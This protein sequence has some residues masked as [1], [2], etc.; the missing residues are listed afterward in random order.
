MNIL[1]NTVLCR[2]LKS[3]ENKITDLITVT[4]SLFK[5]LK[6]LSAE[7]KLL[8]KRIFTKWEA[9]ANQIHARF[10]FENCSSSRNNVTRHVYGN[11]Q[12]IILNKEGTLLSGYGTVSFPPPPTDSDCMKSVKLELCLFLGAFVK[13]RKANISFVMSV[14]LSRLPLDGFS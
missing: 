13:L 5:S 2:R 6:I 1:A 7:R 9:P 14:R 3:S 8:Y 12:Q 10:H 11:C 4:R